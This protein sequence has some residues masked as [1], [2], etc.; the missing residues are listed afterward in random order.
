MPGMAT[1]ISRTWRETVWAVT[2]V[3]VAVVAVV[4]VAPL[5]ALG[6][7]LAVIVVGLPIL[8]AALSV[9]RGFA[10]LERRWAA[11]LLG[12]TPEGPGSGWSAAGPRDVEGWRAA[13]YLVLH[14]PVAAAACVVAVLG[15]ALGLGGLSYP[16]WY[17]AQPA[18]IDGAALDRPGQVTAVAVTGLVAVLVTPWAV[19]VLVL[20][21]RVLLTLTT[22]SAKTRRLRELTESRS[23]AVSDSADVLRRVERDL[24]DGAQAR[25]AAVA[26]DLGVA[27]DVLDSQPGGGDARHLVDLAFANTH[28]A[29]AELRDLARGIRPAAL[30]HGLDTA[31]STLTARARIPVT[32]SVGSHVR[33]SPPIAAIAY[34]C[35][36]ELLANA[37]KHSSAAEVSIDVRERGTGLRLTVRDNGTGGARIAAGGGLAGLR[38]RVATVDGTL[39]VDSPLGGPTTVA[40]DL[41][42]HE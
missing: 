10:E 40:V 27:R 13:L 39:T 33:P 19:R 14:L 2:A 22:P 23:R 6:A 28:A 1:F 4:C 12:V 32:L 18:S 7:V 16:L 21:D 34:F 25:M 8:T 3:P 31:L 29:I 35:A 15:W 30:D 26:I 9:A 17:R 24:H 36:A 5:L 38:D 11:A 37:L 41:P 20:A 42:S